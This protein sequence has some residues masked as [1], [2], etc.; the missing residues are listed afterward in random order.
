MVEILSESPAFRGHFPGRPILPAVAQLAL[1]EEGIAQL[2]KEDR[3]RPPAIFEISG[4]RLRRTVGPGERLSLRIGAVNEKG[5]HRFEIRSGENVVSGGS[6]RIG[7]DEPSA[8]AQA[9]DFEAVPEIPALG[10]VPHFPPALLIDSLVAR[11]SSGARGRGLIPADS[12]FA[13]AGHA[14]SYLGLEIAAQAAALVEALGRE[15]A[16]G[17]P[18]IGY[19]VAIR[20]ARCY[21]RS[22]PVGEPLD[23]VVLLAGSAPPLSIYE[24]RIERAGRLLVDGT[25]ST[26]IGEGES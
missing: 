25:I 14:P 12:P 20:Q 18:R 15:G 8:S 23:V 17:E 21:V 4:L 5:M 26:W 7:S 6:V 16:V 24:I 1:V 2:N 3:P 13:V 22:L 10:S 9:I 19:L 11:G